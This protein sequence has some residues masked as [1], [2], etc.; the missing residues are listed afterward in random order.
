MNEFKRTLLA[1]LIAGIVAAVLLGTYGALQREPSAPAAPATE[2]KAKAAP[3]EAQV[4]ALDDVARDLRNGGY[5]LYFRHGNRAKWDSVIAFDVYEMATGS[6]ASR[7]SFA[8][9]VCLSAQGREEAAM[10]GKVLRL[11]KVPVTTVV[12][13]PSCRAQQTARLAFGRIDR[14]SHALAHT[15]VTNERNAK[16]FAAELGRVLK[17]VPAGRGQVTVIAAHG[18]TIENHPELFSA[19]EELLK[20]PQETGFWVIARDAGGRLRIVQR[21]ANLGDF[22]ARAIDLEPLPH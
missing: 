17:T 21:F 5:I 13:S 20:L 18:N 9:A 2:P 15:P 19:G 10:I 3:R 7:E 16:A 11:A 1:G 12:A 6:D 4:M 14:V 8:D 22:A